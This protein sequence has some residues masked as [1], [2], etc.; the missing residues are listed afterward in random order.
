MNE[1]MNEWK[2]ATKMLIENQKLYLIFLI[3]LYAG[4]C[5]NNSDI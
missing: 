5:I 2:E 1:W 4:T 3:T